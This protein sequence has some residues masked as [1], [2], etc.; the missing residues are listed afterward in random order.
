MSD[1]RVAS[2]YATSLLELA[3]ERGV[4]EQV[5]EDMLLFSRTA[6]ANRQFGLLLG[7]PIVNNEKK[8]NV[9][10][11]LFADKMNPMTMSFF[12]IASRKKREGILVTVAHEFHDQYLRKK[13]IDKATVT[14]TLPLTDELRTEFLALIKQ[15]TG[16]TVELKEITDPNIIGGF[17]LKVGDYLIDSSVSGKLDQLKLNLTDHT[18]VS[19]L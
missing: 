16:K 7:N 18:Y 1:Q 17:I 12:E 13:G 19:K 3:L 8:F 2:R 4:G 9:L 15:K 6:A 14:T 5:H 11:G 10:K